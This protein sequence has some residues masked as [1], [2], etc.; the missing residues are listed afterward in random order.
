MPGMRNTVRELEVSER[1]LAWGAAC[2]RHG[3]LTSSQWNS[4]QVTVQQSVVSRVTYRN[5]MIGRYEPIE[6]LLCH[7]DTA[8]SI[9][10]KN[11][12]S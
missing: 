3:I 9:W 8:Y 4:I 2:Y 10:P 11:F 12:M 5:Y 7:K 6:V 1:H